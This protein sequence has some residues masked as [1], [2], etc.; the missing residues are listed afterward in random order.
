LCIIKLVILIFIIFKNSRR[1]TISRYGPILAVSSLLYFYH[2]VGM[3]AQFHSFMV[4]K[5][6]LD[7]NSLQHPH[8]KRLS[9]WAKNLAKS[10]WVECAWKYTIFTSLIGIPFLVDDFIYKSEFRPIIL[11]I[12]IVMMFITIFEIVRVIARKEGILRTHQV[13]VH[14][15]SFPKPTPISEL[16]AKTRYIY[17]YTRISTQFFHRERN[18]KLLYQ[19]GAK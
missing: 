1:D 9:F 12:V 6:K 16:E 19:L 5:K 4:F 13:K 14:E 15:G 17:P 7:V 8:G 3:I 11:T 2:I 10:Y 18:S